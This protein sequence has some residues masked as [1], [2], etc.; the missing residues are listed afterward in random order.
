MSGLH[1]TPVL[2]SHGN[3]STQLYNQS[4]DPQIKYSI[5]N[6]CTICTLLQFCQ[7][8]C[9]P[10]ISAVSINV[11]MFDSIYLVVVVL[12]YIQIANIYIYIYIIFNIISAVVIEPYYK[13]LGTKIKIHNDFDSKSILLQK[14][15]F[16]PFLK[17]KTL[18]EA[19]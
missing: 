17:T 19:L 9:I 11:W 7:Y 6:K 14:G 18:K 16:S 15:F 12:T 10:I 2:N 8:L 1:S 3:L 13:I 4:D 5:C